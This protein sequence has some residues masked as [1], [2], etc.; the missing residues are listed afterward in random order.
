MK[1]GVKCRAPLLNSNKAKP[2]QKLKLLP[3]AVNIWQALNVPNK[4]AF[5]NYPKPPP[6][7][8]KNSSCAAWFEKIIMNVAIYFPNFM[9][10]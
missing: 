7:R 4:C 5:V 3:I 1:N 6:A 9:T 10:P 2:Q 8:F